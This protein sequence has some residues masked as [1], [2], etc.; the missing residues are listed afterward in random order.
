MGRNEALYWESMAR[1]GH[2]G[3]RRAPGVKARGRGQAFSDIAVTLEGAEELD[4]LLRGLPI[5]MQREVMKP[6]LRE[7]SKL[8]AKDAKARCPITSRPHTVKGVKVFKRLR[9]SIGY[10]IKQYKN[11]GNWVSII[12]PRLGRWAGYHAHLVEFGTGPRWRDPPEMKG[13]GLKRKGRAR[14]KG[15]AE[16][17]G[18][19]GGYTGVMP[20]QPFMRPAFDE[21]KR[22]AVAI[23]GRRARDELEKLRVQDSG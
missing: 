11:S 22:K 5:W 16:L 21:N 3:Y 13:H 17:L 8:I 4:A 19:R 7:A 20:A 23:V 12:G 10:K 9:K 15:F 18:V 1:G 6:A 2:S 14:L